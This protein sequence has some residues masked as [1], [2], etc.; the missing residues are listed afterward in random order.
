VGCTRDYF[1]S[2][3]NVTCVFHEGGHEFPREQVSEFLDSMMI[4]SQ[5]PADTSTLYQNEPNPFISW[6]RIV[7]AV[8]RGGRVR[9]E[10]FDAKGRL[11]KVLADGLRGPDVYSEI[12]DGTNRNGRALPAGTY[13]CRLKAPDWSGTKKMNLVR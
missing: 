9:L 11:V 4:D 8:K 3:R 13:F 2:L 7:Y 10:I 1:S 6:T 5:I 12:W